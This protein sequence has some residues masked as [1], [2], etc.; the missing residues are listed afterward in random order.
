MKINLNKNL[1]GLDG[2]EIKD[3]NIGKIVANALASSS[4]GDALKLMTWATKLYNGEQLDLDP[5]D[6]ITFKEFVNSNQNFNLLLKAQVLET[7]IKNE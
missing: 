5:S 3:T 1:N 2:Q 7:L 4:Q 6:L